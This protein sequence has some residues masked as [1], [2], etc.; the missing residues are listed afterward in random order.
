VGEKQGFSKVYHIFIGMKFKDE[1]YLEGY[2]YPLRV[3][4]VSSPSFCQ[5]HFQ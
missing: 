5:I 1:G 2:L 3:R 4:H